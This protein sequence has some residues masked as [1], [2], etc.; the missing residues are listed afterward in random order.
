M[1]FSI[2]ILTTALF[3]AS[4]L[5]QSSATPAQQKPPAHQPGVPGA[6]SAAPADAEAPPPL[7]KPD[8]AKEAAIRHLMDLTQTSKLG[9]NITNAI[10]GQVRGVMGQRIQQPDQLQKFMDTFTQKF[11]VAAPSSAVV[12]AEIPVYAH[13]FSMED[14]QGLIKFYESPLGQRVVKSLPDVVQ[15]TQQAG[16]QL[17]QKAAL[18]VLRSMSTEYP[19]LKTMLPPEGG[20][21]PAGGGPPPSEVRPVPGGP[22]TP[23]TP[24]AAPAPGSPR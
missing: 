14:I 5:A 9:D 4:A 15:R 21:P 24:P 13:Y 19:E 12:D 10:T 23:A 8:P 1:R 7:E 20:A 16:V 17:D 18:D 11:A 2:A 6:Q 22:P 3:A